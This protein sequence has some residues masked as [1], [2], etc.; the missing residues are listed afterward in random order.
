[1]RRILLRRAALAAAA[2]IAAGALYALFTLP[3]RPV[4]LDGPPPARTVVAGG[5]HVHTDRSDGTRGIDAIA[6]AASRAGLGFVIFTDHGDGTRAPE[7]PS[8]R[9]GVLCIDAVELNTTAG[10][11]VALGLQGAS[12]YPL[13]GEAADVIDDIHRFGGRAVIAHPDSPD[14]GLSWRGRGLPFDGIEWINADSEWRDD[15]VLRLAGAAARAIVRPTETIVSLFARPEASLE[16]WDAAAATRPIFGLAAV[17]AHGGFVFGE[18][19]GEWRGLALSWPGYEAMFRVVTQHVILNS[20]PSGDARTDATAVL[21]AIFEGRTY[22]V[23]TGYASPAILEFEAVQ[24]NRRTTMGGALPAG[25]GPTTFRGQVPQAPGARLVLFQNGREIASAQGRL[26]RSVDAAAG[27]IYRLEA[28]F[29]G[30]RAPWIVSNPIAIGRID[31]PDAAPSGAV[32]ASEVVRL[33]ADGSWR[34]ELGHESDAAIGVEHGITLVLNY[35]L[36]SDRAKGPYTAI[37][38]PV[39]RERDRGFDRVVIAGRAN[40]PTR[41]SVQVRLPVGPDGLRFGKS[42]YLDETPR[43]VTVPIEEM[44]PIGGTTTQQPIV[45]HVQELL[46]VVDSVTTKPGSQ[47]TIWL[48]YIGLGIGSTK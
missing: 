12:P 31:Q 25:A 21:G 47:G 24:G 40:R 6:A 44:H 7:P 18:D 33:P 34:T 5:Y 4:R 32:P 36:G 17:D 1:V 10:H 3:P 38:R 39:D 45:A 28:R 8:Y 11:L 41:V 27:G 9:H 16:R 15:P 48:N 19:S 43:T 13:A 26:E 35:R 22:S 14:P 30:A 37:V 42:I 2:L 29:P 20:E 46:F 23:V